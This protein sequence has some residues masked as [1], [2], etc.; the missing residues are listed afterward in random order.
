MTYTIAQSKA[1][2]LTHG[3]RPGIE[4]ASSWILIVFVSAAP[5]KEL[6]MLENFYSPFYLKTALQ[7][8]HNFTEYGSPGIIAVFFHFEMLTQHMISSRQGF[9]NI[10]RMNPCFFYWPPGGR[11]CWTLERRAFKDPVQRSCF[12]ES[13]ETLKTVWVLYP[14]SKTKS[15]PQDAP[16]PGCTINFSKS[17]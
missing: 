17:G 8:P 10:C 3:V 14:L 12:I 7:R 6:P 11:A 13:V 15:N 16:E 1:G 5:Q 2:S 9:H 4:H